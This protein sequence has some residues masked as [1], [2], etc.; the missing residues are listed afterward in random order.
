VVRIVVGG[1]VWVVE[2]VWRIVCVTG[3]VVGENVGVAVAV[4]WEIVWV[5][6]TV[7]WEII[8][9][10]VTVVWGIVGVGDIVVLKM[11][12]VDGN[13]VR[14]IVGVGVT[15][16]VMGNTT[17]PEGGREAGV[18]VIATFTGVCRVLKP[19]GV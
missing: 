19:D 16:L 7:V 17:S 10:A 2:G 18:G 6:V 8:G 4:V 13:V 15:C 11:V 5:A 1:T 3:M 12:G 14:R 9:V